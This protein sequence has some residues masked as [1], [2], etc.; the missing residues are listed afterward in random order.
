MELVKV[1]LVVALAL[2]APPSVAAADHIKVAVVPGVAVNIDAAR[3]D[4]L[5]QDMAEALS[6]ELEVDA[7]GGL[8]VRRQLP[9]EGVPPDCVTT[10]ACTSSVATRTGAT[11]LLFVVMVDSGGAVQVDTTWVDP[12]TGKNTSR[13][14]IDLT[15]TS[16]T[17]AKAKFASAAHLLLPDAT[18]KPKP[19]AGLD[20]DTKMTE[21][22]PR[23]FTPAS[24]AT[25]AL[26]IVGLG[27]G[28]GFGTSARS[29]YKDCD[30]DPTCGS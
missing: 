26:A 6:S 30:A 14:A 2:A 17:D 4:A 21:R 29:K 10:A 3:V 18:V 19:Q 20:I 24:Y 5:T 28:I 22:T 7:V 15:S 1:R 16:D 11:Q 12:T 23:H 8:E 13:P 27:I 9:P 25:G